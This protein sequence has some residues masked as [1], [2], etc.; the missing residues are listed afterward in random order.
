[1][2]AAHGSLLGHHHDVCPSH[3]AKECSS[4]TAMYQI[5]TR[6]ASTPADKTSFTKA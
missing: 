1:M 5:S 4:I 6:V 2:R 3:F